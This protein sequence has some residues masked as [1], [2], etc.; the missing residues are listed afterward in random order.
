MNPE[1]ELA[2]LLRDIKRYESLRRSCR[3]AGTI[4]VLDDAIDEARER[5]K[6]LQA[7]RL[8]SD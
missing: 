5:L 7:D 1:A 8:S 4:K 6:A 2:A 3:D